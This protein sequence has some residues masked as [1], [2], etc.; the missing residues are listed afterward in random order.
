VTLAE[1]YAAQLA[2]T[3]H[4]G[5]LR[6]HAAAPFLAGAEKVF[7]FYEPYLPQA[8]RILDWGCRHAPDACLIRARRAALDIEGCDLHAPG[9]YRCFYDAARLRY[10][11]LLDTVRLPYADASFDAVIAAG[12]LEHVAMDYESLKELHRV[13]R[14]EGR[15]IVTYLPNRASVEEWRLRRKGAPWHARLYSRREFRDLLLHTG[16]LPVVLGYQT[17][18]DLLPRSSALAS[19]LRPLGAERFTSCLCAVASRVSSL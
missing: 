1:I 4:D 5:Y 2:E 6:Q 3:P 15:L 9:A 18:L 16:F 7:E 12:V 8:G 10:L 11:Q 13:L 17:Q 14:P 19:L